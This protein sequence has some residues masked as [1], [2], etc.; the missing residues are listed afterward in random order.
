MVAGE[1]NTTKQNIL[2]VRSVTAT[3]YRT[4]AFISSA[5]RFVAAPI[6]V[7]LI[8][9]CIFSKYFTGVFILC[10]LVTGLAI[11]IIDDLVASKKM[12]LPPP[13]LRG[14]SG[15]TIRFVI[16]VIFVF[17]AIYYIG[18]AVQIKPLVL[19]FV[20][21]AL[22]IF[23]VLASKFSMLNCVKI[24]FRDFFEVILWIN[25][26]LCALV[27]CIAGSFMGRSVDVWSGAVSGG[28]HPI[29]GF[30]IG[31]IIG[32]LLNIVGGGFIATIL[33]ID[34]NI[35]KLAGEYNNS[36]NQSAQTTSGNRTQPNSIA[37][38][39]DADEN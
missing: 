18:K 27:G 36:S 5:V 14:V 34:A 2:R 31:A 15:M 22:G 23:G 26:I 12:A 17:L 10:L 16:V 9:V 3:I 11:S 38:T 30:I 19:W 33:N 13:L 21:T 8:F 20:I 28:G 6:I 4:L 32:I 35:E 37:A 29:L 7:V 1:H 25:L 39:A 24:A